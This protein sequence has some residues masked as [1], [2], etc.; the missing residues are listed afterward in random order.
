M[1]FLIIASKSALGRAPWSCSTT[2]PPWKASTVGIART[3][4]LPG[5]PGFASMSILTILTWSPYSLASSW[6]IGAI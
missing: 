6:M 1:S 3:P 2:W 4:Y 5:V